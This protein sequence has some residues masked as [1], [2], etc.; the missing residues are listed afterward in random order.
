MD[1]SYFKRFCMVCY[2]NDDDGYT[3]LIRIT[4]GEHISDIKQA[5]DN[6]LKLGVHI[7]SIT[8]DSHKSA[9][10]AIKSA[11]PDVTVQCCLVHI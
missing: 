4:D 3:Q 8:C 9:L 10:K 6:L 7:E 5:L 1:A 11:L 2:Q